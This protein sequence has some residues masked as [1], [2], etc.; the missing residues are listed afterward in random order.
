ENVQ[1]YFERE[2]HVVSASEQ[3]ERASERLERSASAVGKALQHEARLD[4]D[5]EREMSFKGFCR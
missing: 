2:R 5:R 1:H 4:I 3:I